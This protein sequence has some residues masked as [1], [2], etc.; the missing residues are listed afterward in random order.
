[1]IDLVDDDGSLRRVASAIAPGPDAWFAGLDGHRLEMADDAHPTVRAI[2]SRRP[3]IVD[4]LGASLR[5][6]RAEDG[7]GA[8]PAEGDD[9]PPRLSAVVVPLIRRQQVLG[10]LTLATLSVAGLDF[11]EE[12]VAFAEELARR[13]A[14][15]VENAR[16]Y[17]R[18]RSV[19]ETLQHS[20]L[21]ER[22]PV[23]P[24]LA[25]AARYIP[26]GPDVEVGGDWYDLM[27]L[28]GG[29]I[30]LAMGDVVGRG[31]RAASLMGQLRNAARAYALE[32]R[33]PRQVVEALNW[34]LLDAG[35]EHMATMIYAVLDGETG[36]LRFVSAGHPPPLLLSPDGTARY[37]DASAGVPV[38]ALA[39][40]SYQEARAVVPPGGTILLYTDGLVEDRST[41]LDIGLDRLREA[42]QQGPED[43]DALCE[44]VVRQ[45]IL[46]GHGHDDAAALAVRLVVLDERL[47][48][49]LPTQP[50]VLA[51]L[52]A[53]LR[54]W[55]H[56]IGASE[57][58]CYELVTACG[59]A[60]TNAIRHAG[61]VGRGHFELDAAVDGAVEIFVRDEGRWREPRADIGGRG[62]G[63]MEAYVD[64]LEIVRGSA[65]TEVRMRRRLSSGQDAAAS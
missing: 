15:G 5:R 50:S 25:A 35:S 4:D 57:Q 59:E 18:Q 63:I 23:V 42:V 19:A 1:V 34:L 10:A 52:R 39:T 36:E 49:R 21:P 33:P 26:G 55:L 28:P 12:T 30:G 6:R 64:D 48:L 58:E 61:S 37:L 3:V 9:S 56:Q 51:P 20:L 32:G 17:A 27:Q 54:R 8:E 65:G 22:F 24:G 47:H 38:G 43:L 53:T 41:P 40:A 31:E 11:G 29:A 14:I 7:T 45:E 13:A 46:A 62:L 16:L 2:R 44:H 60:C